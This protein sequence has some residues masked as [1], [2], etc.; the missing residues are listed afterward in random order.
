MPRPV[1]ASGDVSSRGRSIFEMP[2]STIFAK[3]RIGVALHEEDVVGLEIAMDDPGG[4]RACE[5]LEDLRDDVQRLGERHAARPA[6]ALAEVLAAEQL[7]DE[8]RASVLGAGVED[9]DDVR[10]LDRAHRPRLAGEARDDSLVGGELR[11]DELDRDALA[12][13]DV[14]APRRPRPCRRVR[15][16]PRS[17]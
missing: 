10:A 8:I 2:K 15:R 1:S 4:V 13:A 6:E 12:E 14:L 11:V 17:R 9:R 7:H 3:Q 16:R 5:A